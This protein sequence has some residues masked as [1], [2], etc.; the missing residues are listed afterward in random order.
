MQPTVM[1]LL[2]AAAP[3]TEAGTKYGA[4]SAP[5]AAADLTN[6][7]REIAD[8]SLFFLVPIHPHHHLEF[9]V[10]L[11]PTH[12]HAMQSR[13]ASIKNADAGSG[14]SAD[15]TLPLPGELVPKFDRQMS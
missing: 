9:R 11:H 3:K 8:R 7:R 6:S 15:A 4:A 5:A 2:G 10:D 13:G 12:C 1:R 14:T